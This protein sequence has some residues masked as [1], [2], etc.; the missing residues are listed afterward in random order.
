MA[1]REDDILWSDGS[2]G[3]D[4]SDDSGDSS[5]ST[6]EKAVIV[7][8]VLLT[9]AVFGFAAWQLLTASGGMAPIVEVVDT[10]TTP[11]GDVIVTVQLRNT[12]EV[13]LRSATVEVACTD[14]P[15]QITFTNVP[16]D[17]RRVGQVR[18][19]PETDD[20]TVSVSSWIAR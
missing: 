19:P 18:C 11:T 4:G 17:G 7:V 14:P 3:S 5:P 20:P 2:G 8:S 10:Q 16:V 12:L 6:A 13:G 1:D 9:V 15:T